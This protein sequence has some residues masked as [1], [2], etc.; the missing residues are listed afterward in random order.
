V[1]L[2][3]LIVFTLRDQ[4]RAAGQELVL[5]YRRDSRRPRIVVLSGGAGMFIMASLAQQVERLTCITPVQDAVE[6]Y[7]RASSL[8]SADYVEYVPPTPLPAQVLARLNDGTSF[9]IRETRQVIDDPRFA[10]SHVDEL[11]LR[12]LNGNAAAGAAQGQRVAD[13]VLKAIEQADALVLGPGS[14][15]GSILPNLLIDELRAAIQRAPARKIYVCNLITE[16]G[17]TTGFSVGDHIRAIKHYGG[18]APDYVL[19]NAQRLEPEV[20]QRYEAANYAPVELD[21]EAYEETAVLQTADGRQKGLLL[22]GATVIEADLSSA[23]L[24][25]TASLDR[26]GESR[27]VRMLRHDPDKLAAAILAVLR[28]E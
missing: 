3:G 26:P 8:F 25:Y 14:L 18:F 23:L 17:L 15:F 2:R 4:E 6:Y 16:P 28:R 1:L 7:Y 10:R 12:W 13:I 22:E 20:R 11:T 5:G 24:Q 21:P 9:D 19:V 27:A